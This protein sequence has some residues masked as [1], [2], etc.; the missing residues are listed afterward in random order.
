MIYLKDQTAEGFF[1]LTF[2]AHVAIGPVENITVYFDGPTNIVLAW[3]PPPVYVIHDLSN[4]SVDEITP[5]VEV[6]ATK[7]HGVPAVSQGNAPDNSTS[8]AAVTNSTFPEGVVGNFSSENGKGFK[9]TTSFLL[10]LFLPPPPHFP[11]FLEL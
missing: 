2:S 1:S 6:N 9:I 8:S 7:H 5:G 3:D 11:S 10:L 4:V